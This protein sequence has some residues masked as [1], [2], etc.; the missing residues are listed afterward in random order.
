[1]RLAKNRLKAPPTCMVCAQ[2]ID[3]APAR[4]FVAGLPVHAG[5]CLKTA[6]EAHEKGLALGRA[7]RLVEAKRDAARM[8]GAVIQHATAR[9]RREEAIDDAADRLRATLNRDAIPK[10]DA[11]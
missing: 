4:R 6:T 7:A 5:A 8:A 10:D 1:M 9:L 2:A 3:R 11:K